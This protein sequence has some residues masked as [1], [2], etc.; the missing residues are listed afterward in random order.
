MLEKT[1]KSDFDDGR[2]HTF[3]TSRILISSLIISIIHKFGNSDSISLMS[4]NRFSGEIFRKFILS[5]DRI[6]F[7]NGEGKTVAGLDEE[8]AK[9]TL[10]WN[11]N[12]HFGDR[13]FEIEEQ[14]Q[15]LCKIIHM[16]AE[17]PNMSLFG[18]STTVDEKITE[19][20]EF[21]ATS[22]VLPGVPGY[23]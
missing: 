12:A 11:L 2:N 3:F 16:S 17:F 14:G 19:F 6:M 1:V 13:L 20:C 10:P 15:D 9:S 22:G 4:Q 21:L 7:P 8:W 5:M 23:E 18:T